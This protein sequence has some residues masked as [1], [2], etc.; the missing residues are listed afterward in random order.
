MVSIG[1]ASANFEYFLYFEYV[2]KLSANSTK[3]ALSHKLSTWACF[4]FL[5]PVVFFKVDE[6]IDEAKS[7]QKVKAVI[8]EQFEITP[9]AQ[10]QLKTHYHL[11]YVQDSQFQNLLLYLKEATQK[12]DL[13]KRRSLFPYQKRFG[14]KR[15]FK[16]LECCGPYQCFRSHK[17]CCKRMLISALRFGILKKLDSQTIL[18]M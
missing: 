8:F 14:L 11:K 12:P 10:K 18:N 17:L 5:L 4:W 13:W 9:D 15:K 7:Y 16:I 6:L 2:S 1:F 3:S